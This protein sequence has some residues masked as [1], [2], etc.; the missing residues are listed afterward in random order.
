MNA[1]KIV[2]HTGV[3][4]ACGT[5]PARC[6]G[7]TSSGSGGISVSQRGLNT[8]VL[9][10]F[11]LPIVCLVVAVVFYQNFRGAGDELVML[12]VVAAILAV[13]AG[14]LRPW[15]DRFIEM[16]SVVSVDHVSDALIVEPN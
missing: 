2:L 6:W 1:R 7:D 16:M 14:L 12:G 4:S 11:G 13:T 3:P 8:V 10:V 5:C 15:Q 9:C